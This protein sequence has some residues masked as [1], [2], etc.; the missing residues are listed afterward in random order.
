MP[1]GGTFVGNSG[2]SYRWKTHNRKLQV[3]QLVV[4]VTDAVSLPCLRKS[5]DQLVQADS[6]DKKPLVVRHKHRR[7]F[8]VWRMSR[9]AFLEVKPEVVETLDSLISE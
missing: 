7:H 4:E 3:C 1:S 2:V 9:H 8:F 5:F 6:E